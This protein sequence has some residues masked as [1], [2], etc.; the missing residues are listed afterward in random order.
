ME[1]DLNNILNDRSSGS[2]H[3]LKRC[4]QFFLWLLQN[5]EIKVEVLLEYLKRIRQN[6]P[7]FAILMH[8][9][10]YF[11][12]QLNDGLSG[13]KLAK[14]LLEYQE[15]WNNSHR[16]IAASLTGMIQLNKSKVL[17]HSNSATIHDLFRFFAAHH[18]QV[19]VFQTLSA[20]NNEG[21]EQAKQ[22]SG[23]G[24]KVT[25]L[26]EASIGLIF[27]E[28]DMVI[29]G[30]DIIHQQ[31]FIN[32]TGSLAIA[33]MAQYFKKPLYV[34][35]DSRKI[36]QQQYG[37]LPTYNNMQDPN[38]IATIENEGMYILNYY[39]EEVSGN[40]VTKYVFEQPGITI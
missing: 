35:A 33:L 39:F 24:F 15:T 26:T 5:G 31:G 22:V 37:P 6:F 13:E 10:D 40:L 23:A 3:I 9:I 36:W 2:A 30:A 29:L 1:H 27:N 17:L 28:V 38:E 14:S 18:Y 19:E 25:L 7:G 8:F 12:K 16:K 11:E 34:A 4:I 20:P 32:K 21:L